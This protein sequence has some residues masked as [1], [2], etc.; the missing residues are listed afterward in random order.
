[1]NWQVI[2]LG[3]FLI[4]AAW[5]AAEV[6]DDGIIVWS[7]RAQRLTWRLYFTY[8]TS[9]IHGIRV[10]HRRSGHHGSDG[11]HPGNGQPRYDS[12]ARHGHVPEDS[13]ESSDLPV[14]HGADASHRTRGHRTRD[15][16]AGNDFLPRDDGRGWKGPV[17]GSALARYSHTVGQT[18]AELWTEQ[19]Q[20]WLDDNA[21]ALAE[22]RAYM[23]HQADE[24][25][26]YM[27]AR[28]YH[29]E[30]ASEEV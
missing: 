17:E 7:G 4:G 15:S 25:A 28:G 5:Y 30:E 23:Q 6:R 21:C 18:R 14:L 12:Q 13:Q 11:S 3:F 16:H 26:A 24:W 20:D 22:H 10:S 1:M 8:Y 29:T 2:G 19:H 27:R 9:R